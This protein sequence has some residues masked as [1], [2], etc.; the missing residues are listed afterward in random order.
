[1]KIGM[2]FNRLSSE[3]L[4]RYASKVS[5]AARFLAARV[6]YGRQ[7]ASS[8]KNPLK[9]ETVTIILLPNDSTKGK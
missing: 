1:M 9:K 6:F 3:R 8:G 2:F 7:D 5:V 4:K